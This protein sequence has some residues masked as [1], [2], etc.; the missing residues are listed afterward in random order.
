MKHIHASPRHHQRRSPFRRTLLTGFIASGIAAAAPSTTVVISQVYGGGGNSGATYK[1]DF[2]EL[3][4][5]SGSAV[6]ITGWSVQYASSTGTSWSPATLTGSI[7]AGG[8]FLVR[9]GPVG[10]VGADLPTPDILGS[11]SINLG[12]SAGKVALANNSTALTVANPS[13]GATV[14]DFV[15]YGTANGFEGTAAAPAPSNTTSMSRKDSGSQ[16]T[17]QNSTDFTT[18]TPAPRNS[19]STPYQP[20]DTAAPVIS[21]YTPANNATGV[22]LSATLSAQF[23]EAIAKGTGN[24]TLKKVSD[25]STVFTIPVTDAAVA[26][27]GSTATITLPS[28]LDGSTAFYVNIAAGAF[29]DLAN[30]NFAGISDSSTWT[31]TTIVA[32]LTPP[33][34]STLSPADDSTNAFPAGN[35]VITYNETIAAGTGSLV[36]KKSSDDSVVETIA[37]PSALVQVSGS[38]ATV[39]PASVLQYGASYYVEIAAGTFKDAANNGS[40]SLSGGTA[41]NFTTRA[42][43]QVVISQYYEGLTA[44]DRYVELKN[45]TASPLSLTGYRLAAWS[46]TAPSDNEGWKSGT[47][48][49]DRVTVLDGITIPANGSY[50][51]CEPNPTVPA[52]A[53]NN[54]DLATH[55][56]NPSCTD[57]NGDDSVVLYQGSG[58]TQDEVV[59]A[60]SLSAVQ[61]QDT[62]IYRISDTLQGFD[63]V[64]GTSYLNF[65]GTWAVKTLAEVNGAAYTDN[66]YLKASQ[67][68]K[69]L[70]L[71]ITPSS[72]SEGA[73]N[74]AATAT[75][76]LSG[77]V[78]DELFITVAVSD[79][80]EASAPS[81]VSIP[82]GSSSVQFP[83]DAVNDLYQ[84]GDRPVTVTVSSASYTPASQ[85]ITVLDEPSDSALPVVINEVDADQALTDGNEFIELYNKSDSPV[86]LDGVVIVLY[87][88]TNDLSY[89]TID[90]T[91]KTIA[92]H[93]YFVIG[94]ATVP[95]VDLTAFTTNGIENGPDAVA[96][97]VGNAADFPNG[98]AVTTTTKGVL[99][100]AVVYDT[101]D[102]DDTGLINALTPGKPQIDEGSTGISDTNSI[103]RVPDGGAAF[104]TSLFVSQAPTPGA[105]NVIA[106]YGTWASSNAGGQTP[107]LDYDNDG[108]ENGIEYFMNTPAGFTTSPGVVAGKITWPNG[109][110]LLPAD[111][112]TKFF[113]QT[114]TDLANWT[115]LPSNAAGL[116]NSAG[117]LEYTLP[118]GLPVVFVRLVV[119]P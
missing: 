43:P 44:T 24:I 83:I 87:N 63:F 13:G 98:T 21:T 36:I 71:S 12:G 14:V 92:A 90:L 45:L 2:V 11:T 101:N 81:V 89:S 56:T 42:A 59:D 96:L 53:A 103:S 23:N 107:D 97:Y 66:W 94:S 29:K 49:T 37:V 61:G 117:S 51:I 27:S 105:T 62:S 119:I 54:Y 58:F 20:G 50:L 68:P 84:D 74:A 8:Y 75:V 6:N 95:N 65:T 32:D 76:S 55:P 10:T 78:V 26:V 30:N 19:S 52:Y 82:A 57:F 9:L 100:D 110:K 25:N 3:H 72:F 104:D 111:Y 118:T 1:N 112:G 79:T 60:V 35:L 17:D 114:S 70:A 108:V 28:A 99:V 88:G 69:V 46:D 4:N 64:T 33:A 16:D 113:V 31:F 93:D 7:P 67:P 38:T 91:G 109:G 18:G 34:I 5:I 39:N 85:I 48:T 116:V 15:G 86:V 40:T 77:P 22:A 106:G 115:S 102:A 73:G 41:W 47:G 80:T